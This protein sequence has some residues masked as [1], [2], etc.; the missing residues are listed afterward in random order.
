MDLCIPKRI[1]IKFFQEIL[2]EI[3]NKTKFTLLSL[4]RCSYGTI[5]IIV[6]ILT[7]FSSGVA[8]GTSVGVLIHSNKHSQNDVAHFLSKE[9]S[10]SGLSVTELEYNDFLQ[11][12]NDK[13]S[14]LSV[15]VLPDS[16]YFPA[17][18]AARLHEY[19]KH[20]GKLV[21]LGGDPFSQPLYEHD[22]EWCTQQ[23]YVERALESKATVLMVD[24]NRVEAQAW[25]NES[26]NKTSSS[27]VTTIEESGKKV[28]C[29]QHQS[30]VKSDG[31][32]LNVTVPE[33]SANALLFYARADDYT[34]QTVVSIKD[35]NGGKYQFIIEVRPWWTPIVVPLS[36]FHS[37]GDATR[38]G[39]G[40]S[41]PEIHS[42]SDIVQ[43]GFVMAEVRHAPGNHTVYVDAIHGMTLPQGFM[44]N[45]EGDGF[46]LCE[47]RDVYQIH[48]AVKIQS[49]EGAPLP[50]F[51]TIGKYSGV[52]SLGF[53]IL[54]QSEFIPL[55]E[56]KDRFDRRQGWAGGLVINRKGEWKDSCWAMFGITEQSWYLD[57]TFAK[58]LTSLCKSMIDASILSAKAPS[59]NKE[60]EPSPNIHLPRV[61]ISN[62]SFVLPDGKP[63]FI[64]GE[65]LG[66][67]LYDRPVSK[68][69]DASL[70][71]LFRQLNKIGVNGLR[72]LNIGT[73]VNNNDLDLLCSTAE[74]YGVYLLLGATPSPKDKYSRKQ[75]LEQYTGKLA[76][77]FK[78]KTV[79]LGYDLM[80]EPYLN[81]VGAYKNDKGISLHD[82][83]GF[84]KGAYQK[85]ADSLPFEEGHTPNQLH[86]I[87]S[88]LSEPQNKEA[89]QAF[90]AV[91]GIFGEW[92][93]WMKTS[94]RSHGDTHPVSVGYNL[95][96][97][98]LPCNTNL[99]FSCQHTYV[100]PTGY[101][102]VMEEITTM[103]RLHQ[104]FPDK[105]ITLGEFGYTHGYI[106]KGKPLSIQAQALGEIT[107]FLYSWAHG[108]NGAFDWQAY[109]FDPVEYPIIAK[110]SADKWEFHQQ[111][112]RFHGVYTW[113]GTAE[114]MI[115]P[116]GA[117]MRFLS[118]AI[119][120]GINRG[121]IKVFNADT[122]IGTAFNYQCSNCMI[123]G[124]KQ[125][126]DGF[127]SFSSD[128]ERVVGLYWTANKATLFSSG[129]TVVSLDLNALNKAGVSVNAPISGKFGEWKIANG[130]LEI[131]LLAGEEV[132]LGA[133]TT[134]D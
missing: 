77:F 29:F 22:N 94:I 42:V 91:D 63:L 95:W 15:V 32:D 100:M 127:L 116:A 90:R 35:K 39:K 17:L 26:K 30:V 119:H 44:T 88:L 64:I 133:K 60:S 81:E 5:L 34:P 115:K 82:V 124:A 70:D 123:V 8:G 128:E 45:I 109:D 117:A 31:F 114:G 104:L 101:D 56:A 48:D 54:G 43:I 107:H 129:D 84:E 126:N 134:Q 76:D 110:W 75:D 3:A 51:S 112:E 6:L 92:I 121:N 58:Y 37:V 21:T 1:L 36:S 111:Y 19:L 38:S 23:E 11:K 66:G 20:G 106:L 80:N 65:N 118:G 7:G 47:D 18:G 97:A 72:I 131:Q 50:G 74:R 69:D 105:P 125:S 62:G 33:S 78:N 68:Y 93:N 25:K 113:D 28:F 103:D 96:F 40:K 71:K 102:Y 98:A 52:S 57:T 9:L 86:G 108:Y 46:V 2:L 55:L 120:N 59:N 14:S 122:Q 13:L 85:Y 89:A 10:A 83:Y 132:I 12:N 41:K 99:D 67:N 87:D 53:P 61:T 49:F 27:K 24:P 130:R 79:L 16:S 4:A 73:F